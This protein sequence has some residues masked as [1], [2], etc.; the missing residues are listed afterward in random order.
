M[1]EKVLYV[2][3]TLK[4]IHQWIFQSEVLYINIL[5][6]CLITELLLHLTIYQ[7]SCL[8]SLFINNFLSS[9]YQYLFFRIFHSCQGISNLCCTVMAIHS[10]E[11]R[12]LGTHILEVNYLIIL[13]REDNDVKKY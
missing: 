8:I 10:I 12:L 7:Y 11:N 4:Y 2:Q 3:V 9:F 5:Y 6:F 1:K 13:I